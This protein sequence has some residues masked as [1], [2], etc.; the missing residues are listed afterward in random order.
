MN[1]PLQNNFCQCPRCGENLVPIPPLSWLKCSN[2]CGLTIQFIKYK[3]TIIQRIVLE[4]GEFEVLWVV[5]TKKL[6]KCY[7]HLNPDDPYNAVNVPWLP[8]DITEEKIKKLLL[9]K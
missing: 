6:N 5:D 3:N 7:I 2:E 1:S 9:L 8:F 4:I